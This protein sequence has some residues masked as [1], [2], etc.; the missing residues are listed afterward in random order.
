MRTG[1]LAKLHTPGGKGSGAW[2]LS[3][4]G[5]AMAGQGWSPYSMDSSA[6]VVRT[7]SQTWLH[8]PGFRRR[9]AL[10]L[11]RSGCAR[12][13]AGVVTLQLAGTQ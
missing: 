7:C 6:L 2:L 13:G 1:S 10:L 4:S 8:T 11:S 3:T 9:G 12:S 5:S